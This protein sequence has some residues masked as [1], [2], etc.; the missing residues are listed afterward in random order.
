MHMLKEHLRFEW[1]WLKHCIYWTEPGC[2]GY[3]AA[4]VMAGLCGMRICCRT[5]LG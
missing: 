4:A 3:K 5:M 2:N 1:H